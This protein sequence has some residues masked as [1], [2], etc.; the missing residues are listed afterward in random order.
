[1]LFKH[2]RHVS[3]LLALS[4]APAFGASQDDSLLAA[5]D[6]YRA[7]DAMK[8][9]RHAKK[10]DAQHLLTPWVDYWRLSLRLED[11]QA[12]EVDKFLAAYGDTYVGEML[13][14]EWLKV[15]GKRADWKEF[16][17]HAAH[18]GREAQEIDRKSTR[19]EASHLNTAYA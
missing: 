16:D 5:F 2:F 13:R 18:F 6:A 12:D 7:G 15:L 8:L 10:L 19:L 17:P 11:T 14:T 4:A 1:M 9:S 3:L